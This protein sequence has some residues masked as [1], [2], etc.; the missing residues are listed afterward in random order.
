[1]TAA[2]P[3]DFWRGFMYALLIEAI[4]IAAGVFIAY[5]MVAPA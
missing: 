1:M 5:C 2:R 4:M 3:L